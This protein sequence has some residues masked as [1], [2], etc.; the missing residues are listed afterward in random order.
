MLRF[1]MG[2][3]FAAIISPA[4]YFRTLLAFATNFIS[5]TFTLA[6]LSFRQL[7]FQRFDLLNISRRLLDAGLQAMM[8]IFN[9]KYA[10]M[11]MMPEMISR[12]RLI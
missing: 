4:A 7:E 8:R 5:F 10:M 3:V 12:R 6:M 2:E 11:K 9:A 1:V